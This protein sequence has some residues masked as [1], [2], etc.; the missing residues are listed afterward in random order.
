MLAAIAVGVSM[1]P[2]YQAPW[3]AIGA[4]FALLALLDLYAGLKMPAPALVRRVP[5]SLALGVRSEVQA[6]RGECRRR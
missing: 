5:G 2:E 4:G 6:A 1:F 3:T